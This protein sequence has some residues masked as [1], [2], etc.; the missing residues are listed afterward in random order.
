ML[1][2]LSWQSDRLLTDRSPVRARVEAKTLEIFFTYFNRRPSKKKTLHFSVFTFCYKLNFFYLRR[3]KI[4]IIFISLQAK[5]NNF[6]VK[7]NSTYFASPS[8]KLI[9]KYCV[10]LDYFR[11]KKK[12]SNNFASTGNRTRTSC[13][14]GRCNNHY[15]TPAI[16]KKI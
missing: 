13:L 2:W 5:K 3:F 10:A 14:E 4:F 6:I 11:I 12:S 15:A 7:W 1:P 8:K 16:S 9:K